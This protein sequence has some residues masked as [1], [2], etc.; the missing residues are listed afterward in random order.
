L[1]LKEK[2][3]SSTSHF[4]F[5]TLRSRRFQVGF[6]RVNLH[7]PALAEEQVMARKRLPPRALVIA[8]QVDLKA[9]VE[10]S[11]SHFSFKRLVPGG[12]SLG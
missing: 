12:F 10:T 4:S 7:R 8:A 9:E 6:H 11:I 1:N 2:V 5:N 3:E